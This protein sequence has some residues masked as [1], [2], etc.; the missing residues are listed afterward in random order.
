M[1]ARFPSTEALPTAAQLLGSQ[2]SKLRCLKCGSP[3][4]LVFLAARP[5]YP[6]LGPDGVLGCSHCGERYPV[7]AGTPRMVVAEHRRRLADTYSRS[8]E[9]LDVGGR[10]S[11]SETPDPELVVKQSTADSFAYEWHQFGGLREEWAKNFADY[12][13]PHLPESLTG[14]QVLDVG[15]GSGRHSFHAAKA[16]AQ[17]VAV[18][19]G[20]SIDVARRNLPATVLT[21][22]ADAEALPFE[23][24]SFDLVMSIGVLHHLPD[25]DRALCTVARFARDGAHVHVY[26]YWVPA[27]SWHRGLLAAVRAAR[28]IT[29]RLPHPVLHAACYPLAVVLQAIF[30]GPYRA[31]RRRPRGRRFAAALPLKTYADYPFSVLVNDQFDRFS[32]PLERRYTNDEVREAMLLAG[33]EEIVVLPN[34]GW[35]ADGRR[36]VTGPTA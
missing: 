20:A 12:M 25:P 35:V 32:A 31:L 23:P 17:V 33:L 28:R 13:R 30:V 9:V 1:P 8:R 5:G 3:V 7:V 18:D 14:K 21:V 2:A 19:L 34:H 22:Q 10:P 26:L 11:A 6:E 15:A 36:P 4:T 24:G 29:I 27:R 16:G